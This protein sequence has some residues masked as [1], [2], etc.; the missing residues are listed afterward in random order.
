MALSLIAMIGT[1]VSVSP[2]SSFAWKWPMSRPSPRASSASSRSLSKR[3]VRK[4]R[5][6]MLHG[7]PRRR[8]HARPLGGTKAAMIRAR[9]MAAMAA[10][11]TVAAMA[12]VVAVGAMVVVVAMVQHGLHLVIRV[13]VGSIP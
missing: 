8:K 5:R 2:A 13:M 11:A 10:T 6:V 3:I 9:V 12:A 7:R 1:P 4:K